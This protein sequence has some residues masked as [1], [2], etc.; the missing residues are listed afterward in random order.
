MAADFTLRGRR[1]GLSYETSTNLFYRDLADGVREAAA[2]RGV[3][4]VVRECEQS[5][6]R[7]RADIA[8]LLATGPLDAFVCADANL[9]FVAAA[10]GLIVVNPEVP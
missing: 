4:V 7:Q 8:D 6:E 1:I 10:E 9:G 5:V 2:A 3:S